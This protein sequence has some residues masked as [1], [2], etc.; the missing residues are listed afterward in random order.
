MARP[1]PD[2][3]KIRREMISIAETLLAESGGQRLVLSDITQRMG[4]SQSYAHRFF[5][6]KKDLVAAMATHWFQEVERETAKVVQS[7]LDKNEKLEAFI[8]AILTIKRNKFDENPAL[9]KAYLTMAQDHLDIVQKHTSKLTEQLTE[10]LDGIVST[11]DLNEAVS[12]VEDATAMFRIPH[13]IALNRAKT[14]DKRAKAVV[15]AVL[16]HLS[17]QYSQFETRN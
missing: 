16:A 3:D 15:A 2:A 4:I 12:L 7:N 6:T 9:F 17:L 10:I 5:A 11:E 14:T 13:M 8:L 1:K